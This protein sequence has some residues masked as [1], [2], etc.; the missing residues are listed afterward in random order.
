MNA[1]KYENNGHGSLKTSK[2]TI[3]THDL[4]KLSLY[5]FTVDP[6]MRHNTLNF[7]LGTGFS[8]FT[9]F[10]THQPQVQRYCSLPTL[11]QAIGFVAV[12]KIYSIET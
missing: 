2:T 1:C 11:K 10:G 9:S 3:L 12:A 4:T 7:I 6:F 8:V 5:R